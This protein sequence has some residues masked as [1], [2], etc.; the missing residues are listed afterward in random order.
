MATKAQRATTQQVRTML[1]SDDEFLDLAIVKLFSMQ[2]EDEQRIKASI[3]LNNV[4]YNKPDAFRMSDFAT[5]ILNGGKLGTYIMEAIGKMLKYVNQLSLYI[6][7]TNAM[8][9][10][11]IIPAELDNYRDTLIYEKEIGS[12][13]IGDFLDY[14][15]DKREA[16]RKK[17]QKEEREKKKKEQEAKKRVTVT[18]TFVHET[19]RAVLFNVNGKNEWFPRKT[20]VSPYVPDDDKEQDIIVKRWIAEQKGLSPKEDDDK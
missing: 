5:W 11:I 12:M 15:S 19:V 7:I 10:K 2:T 17:K 20:L 13:L 14:R 18:G 3:Y 1:Q 6:D 8:N 4:G 9:N 16:E